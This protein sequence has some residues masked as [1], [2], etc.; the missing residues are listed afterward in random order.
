MGEVQR[1]NRV[2]KRDFHDVR[3]ALPD[4]T[5]SAKPPIGMFSS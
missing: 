1:S 4:R 2:G 5:S 3:W